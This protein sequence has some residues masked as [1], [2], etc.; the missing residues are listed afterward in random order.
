M[1]NESLP[2][3]YTPEFKRNVRQLAKRYRNEGSR[4]AAARDPSFQAPALY[5]RKS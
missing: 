1:A 2:V 4:A 5:L 3:V